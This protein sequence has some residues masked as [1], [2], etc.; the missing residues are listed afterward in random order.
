MGADFAAP[1]PIILASAS[2]RR[3]EI[4]TQMG[5]P[6]LVKPVEIEEDIA[7][8]EPVEEAAQRL[9]REKVEACIERY[10]R[11][12]LSWVLGADTLIELDGRP[13]GKPKDAAEAGAILR[14]FSG[15]I[16]RVVTGVSLYAA[17]SG[18]ILTERDISEVRFAPLSD[19]EIAWYAG[20][21]EWQGAAG[22]YRI[23]GR[24]ACLI[25]RIAGSYSTVM[26]LPIRT[27][28]GMLRTTN[29]PF[30]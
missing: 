9:S 6:F 23:Q 25:E 4:L 10:G 26:G 21:G 11:E 19:E 27:I 8:G 16:H 17:S 18:R 28:Y 29:Y 20:T 15:R 7:P 13:V 30:I 24:G 12:R 3:C 1:E 2:P 14:R 5:L 22:G